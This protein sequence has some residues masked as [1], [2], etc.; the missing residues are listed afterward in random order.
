MSYQADSSTNNAAMDQTSNHHGDPQ[1]DA[2]L[3]DDVCDSPDPPSTRPNP[4][5]DGDI[6]AR[7]RRRTSGSQSPGPRHESMEPHKSHART[8]D[9]DRS[10]AHTTA[11]MIW[12]H[13]DSTEIPKTPKK[14]SPSPVGS[15]T[16]LS[17]SKVTLNIRKANEPQSS[18]L[19]SPSPHHKRGG[20]T[21]PPAPG[22]TV[23]SGG[24]SKSAGTEDGQPDYRTPNSSQPSSASPPVELVAIS[25]DEI[26]QDD[27]RMSF[28][29]D[30]RALGSIDSDR[31]LL[32]PTG[33]FPYTELDEDPLEALQ[34]LLQF[35]ITGA[36]ALCRMVKR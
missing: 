12:D 15:S 8:P 1:L 7:K 3:D 26:E 9:D 17:S 19:S 25:D 22:R 2:N 23:K 32:D 16:P 18:E 13:D 35:L 5:D 34:R 36:S 14:P 6:S 31:T 30:D 4:F 24:A 28:S 21:Q 27:D 10:A 11:A 33:Q 29:V 20:S